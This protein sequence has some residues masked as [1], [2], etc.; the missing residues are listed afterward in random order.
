MHDRAILTPAPAAPTRRSTCPWGE[1][2]EEEEDKEATAAA[3]AAKA[4][5]KPSAGTT[6]IGV[7]NAETKSVFEETQRLRNNCKKTN[8]TSGGAAA[9]MNW[10]E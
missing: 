6:T 7:S 4:R 9:C 5:S 3:A 2:G 8:S 1:E 10:S